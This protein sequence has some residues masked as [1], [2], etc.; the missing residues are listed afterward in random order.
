L[1]SGELVECT[2]VI[3][4]PKSRKPDGVLWLK[5]QA[6]LLRVEAVAGDK[7]FGIA[8]LIEEYCVVNLNPVQIDT[9]EPSL[10]ID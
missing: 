3:P 7:A 2:L 8:F 9:A 1:E 4:I 10:V 5:C 6:R